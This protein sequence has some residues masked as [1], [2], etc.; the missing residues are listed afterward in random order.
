MGISTFLPSRYV[1]DQAES[2]FEE[3]THLSPCGSE[4]ALNDVDS[5]RSIFQARG[6]VRRFLTATGA[7]E[8]VI[9]ISAPQDLFCLLIWLATGFRQ[10]SG[11]AVGPANPFHTV[12]MP[13][14]D[15]CS[16][17]PIRGRRRGSSL[18][19]RLRRSFNSRMHLL[20]ECTVYGTIGCTPSDSIRN[21]WK[22]SFDFRGVCWPA[23]APTAGAKN[24]L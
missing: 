2:A 14:R 12:Q 9:V 3:S 4:T 5:T 10:V 18:R 22:F 7:Q 13:A 24:P 19:G 20:T 11:F 16:G 17:R 21:R 6:W 1:F 15:P 23:P 8:G